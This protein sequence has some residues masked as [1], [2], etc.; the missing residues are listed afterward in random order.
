MHVCVYVCAYVYM[1]ASSP[2]LADS[3]MEELHRAPVSRLVPMGQ[4]CPMQTTSS[5][6]LLSIPLPVQQL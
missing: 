6:S 4:E 3:A 5:M 1:C 2:R